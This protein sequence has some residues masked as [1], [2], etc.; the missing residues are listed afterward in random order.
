MLA[1][2]RQIS[3][4]ATRI[5]NR[6]TATVFKARIIRQLCNSQHFLIDGE[7]IIAALT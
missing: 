2:P 4:Y 3:I 5:K 6:C 1:K 7:H